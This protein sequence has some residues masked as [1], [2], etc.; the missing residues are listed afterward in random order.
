MN[1]K[2]IFILLISIFSINSIYSTDNLFSCGFNT[3]IGADFIYANGNFFE[4]GFPD[5]VLSS[6][7]AIHSDSNYNMT[8]SCSINSLNLDNLKTSFELND[9]NDC[10]NGGQDLFYLTSDTNAR[11]GFPLVN[12]K[13]NPSFNYSHYSYKLCVDLPDEFSSIDIF[14]SDDDKYK[15]AGYQCLF[16]SSDL[17]NGKISSCDSEYAGSNQYDFTIWARLYENLNS[18]KCNSDCTSVLDNRVYSACSQKVSTCN[19][20]PQSCDGSLLGAWVNLNDNFE[21]KCEAPWGEVSRSNIYTDKNIEVSDVDNKC[22]NLIS[23]KYSVILD[24]ELVTMNV[25][26]C[27]EKNE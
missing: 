5:R 9:G 12:T 15:Y 11:I 22:L 6:N 27:G 16:K 7:V 24:N 8:M 21:I 20:V 18:L 19:G 17:I 2:I 14:I 26:V 13:I 1:Y 23:K 25:Y 4:P 10:P 3:G